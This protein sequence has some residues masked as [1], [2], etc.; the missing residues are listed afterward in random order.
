MD[1]LEMVTPILYDLGFG[2]RSNM[3][4]LFC[5]SH[6]TH[7]V[8]WYLHGI[9]QHHQ[10]NERESFTGHLVQYCKIEQVIHHLYLTGAKS[11]CGNKR[12]R[13]DLRTLIIGNFT[14]VI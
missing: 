3:F 10:K 2:K 5:M 4:A 12:K 14:F 11:K 6:Y 9:E 1:N 13:H 7:R 8:G